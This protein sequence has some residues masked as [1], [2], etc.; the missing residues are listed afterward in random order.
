MAIYDAR[1]AHSIA[2]AE[3]CKIFYLFEETRENYIQGYFQI[4]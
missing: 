1:F 4:Y 3:Q 2:T